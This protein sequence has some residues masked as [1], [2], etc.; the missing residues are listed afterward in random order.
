[1]IQRSKFKQEEI[2]EQ[3]GIDVRTLRRYQNGERG[4][5]VDQYWKL[6]RITKYYA[7]LPLILKALNRYW[8]VRKRKKRKKGS[9]SDD[10]N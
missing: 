3:L 8:H 1:M 7:I 5:P 4:M 10:A 2:A 6:I 9:K